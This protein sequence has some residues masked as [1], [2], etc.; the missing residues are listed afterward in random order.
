VSETRRRCC[1]RCARISHTHTHT[2]THTRVRARAHRPLTR[3]RRGR[4]S[5]R[6][7]A[8]PPPPAASQTRSCAARCVVWGNVLVRLGDQLRGSSGQPT[9]LQ[10]GADTL[11]CRSCPPS[12]QQDNPTQ[13]LVNEADASAAQNVNLPARLTGHCGETPLIARCCAW[14]ACPWTTPSMQWRQWVRGHWLCHAC[15]PFGCWPARPR[16]V[17]R[18]RPGAEGPGRAARPRVSGNTPPLGRARARLPSCPLAL[19][20]RR[21]RRPCPPTA[22]PPPPVTRPPTFMYTRRPRVLFDPR[23]RGECEAGPLRG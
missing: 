16:G 6:T 11:V 7:W 4:L 10:I 9:V 15:R 8:L 5:W 19:P 1:D 12:I 17:Q 3:T 23:F 21:R 18:G 20:I 14:T 2:Y 13:S 22:P